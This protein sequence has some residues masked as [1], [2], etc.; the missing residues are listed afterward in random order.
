MPNDW[1]VDWKWAYWRVAH[2]QSKA[3]GDVED[4]VFWLRDRQHVEKRVI[5]CMGG[6]AAK[7]GYCQAYNDNMKIIRRWI[8]EI[9]GFEVRTDFELVENWP[10]AAD[11]LH[12]HVAS[13]I[14]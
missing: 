11:K 8:R 7:Y 14:G 6:Y 12:F 13:C 4:F 1:N 3:S 9:G 10:L 5:F 2:E